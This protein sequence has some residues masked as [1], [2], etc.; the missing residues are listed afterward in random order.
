M[1]NTNLGSKL[2][3]S[4]V[5]IMFN[6][7]LTDFIVVQK[8]RPSSLYDES[9]DGV[10]LLMKDCCESRQWALTTNN[11]YAESD[12]HKY[13]NNT[14]INSF[15]ADIK[16]AIKEVKIPYRPG[17][18]GTSLTVNNGSDGLTCRLFLLSGGEVGYK[19]G[20]GD[21]FYVIDVGTTLD[22]FKTE[23]LRISK[24]AW[25]LRSPSS[26]YELGGYASVVQT[27]GTPAEY[28][29]W[30]TYS[31][32][33][34]LG[35]RPALILPSTMQVAEDGTVLANTAPATPG[36]ISVPV[37]IQGGGSVKVSWAASTDA[38]N[39]LEGYKLERSTD[40][41]STWTQIYQGGE[42]SYTNTVAFGTESVMYRVR[43]YDAEGL[44]SGY[45]TSGQVQ[46]VNNHAPAAPNGINVPTAV[47]A[48][49]P[50]VITWG[51]STD[52]DGDTVTYYL[53]RRIDGGD[54]SVVCVGSSQTYTDTVVK[55]W[56]SVVYRVRAKD[57][58]GAYSPYTTSDV[59]AVNNNLPPEIVCEVPNGGD[60]GEI[61][62]RLEVAYT[63]SDEEEEAI[64]VTERIDG[65]ELRQFTAASGDSEVC[66]VT[67][68]SFLPLLNGPHTLEIA[69]SD[70][71]TETVHTLTFNKA[72]T[73]C[74]VTLDAAMAADGP[75]SVC[76]LSVTSFIPA[77]GLLAVEVTNNANDAAPVWEDC[78]AAVKTG[79]NHVFDNK[80]AANGFA[81]N[82][83]V[84][85]ERGPSGHGGHI[86]SIQGGFQ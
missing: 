66:G 2:I 19:R 85:A 22:Y 5:K 52:A 39:N 20:E 34:L 44:H 40:G 27:D 78:T 42:T 83:R 26:Y 25:W 41:G 46:V 21:G 16:S 57:S 28:H 62:E 14:L 74:S 76:A 60:L 47:N 51:T 13:L 63:V 45:R 37:G 11:D 65:T 29:V 6:G 48:G 36:S 86:I 80:T 7:K 53:E 24:E 75:I 4:T 43:A 56:T 10:W 59:R 49:R 72:V 77:D 55:G 32:P 67:G 71:L 3:R 70:G 15:E 35:V 31:K 38:E 54:W 81:F 9:C 8:R 18:S 23:S 84:S 61:S 50:L 12:I 30:K 79:V 82:F 69:A 58:L 1:A 68:A 73:A 33:S 17:N 64:T